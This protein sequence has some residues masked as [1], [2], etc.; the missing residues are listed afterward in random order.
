MKRIFSGFLCCAVLLVS[1]LVG[2]TTYHVAKNGNDAHAGSSSHPWQTI[3]KAAVSMVPGDS[4]LISEGVY[5]ETIVPSRSGAPG[6][7]ITY[8]AYGNDKVIVDGGVRV[9]GWERDEGFFC[10]NPNRYKARIAFQPN[11]RFDIK[12]APYGYRGGLVLQ[13]AAKMNYV[14][15]DGRCKVDSEGAYYLDDGGLPPYTLYLY[16]RNLG[17]GYDPNNYEIVVGRHRKGFDLDRGSDHINVEGLTFRNF[18]DNAIHSNGASHVRFS[19]LTLY[20]NYITGIYLTTKSEDN[21]IERCRFWDNGHG[22]IELSGADRTIIRNNVFTRVDRG[23]GYGGNHGHIWYQGRSNNTVIENNVG[24][25]TGS[26]YPSSISAFIGI[27]GRNNIVRHNSGYGIGTIGI[28]V[29]H[30][31]GNTIVN[32]VVDCS[33]GEDQ[34]IEISKHAVPD[35]L[36][37]VYNN[38]FY[39]GGARGKLG[40][41]GKLFA[42]MLE[43]ETASGYR[44]NSQAKPGFVAPAA[45]DLHLTEGSYCIDRGDSANSSEKDF[46]GKPRPAGKGYDIGA[47]EFP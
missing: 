36:N 27:M 39:T 38:V 22:G 24:F 40:W 43:W 33:M 47:F 28:G 37:P 26:D 20:S 46:D 16:V 6:L 2:A 7:P 10:K 21:I 9:T 30:G 8:K 12:K 42:N 14:M 18:N 19:D 29:F 23:N 4:V 1:S 13:D 25:S 5:Y 35:G 3:G 45:E 31:A 11:P 32:N 34:C 17:K 15:E 41:N 44:N